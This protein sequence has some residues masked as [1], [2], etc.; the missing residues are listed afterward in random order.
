MTGT[1][2]SSRYLLGED[3][4]SFTRYRLFNQVY[5]PATLARLSELSIA[6]DGEVLEIGC[7]IG[8]TACHLAKHLVPQGHVTAF[9][10]AA[11]LV[12][13]AKRQAEDAG[14]ENVTFSCARA[15]DFDYEPARWDL[16][17]SRYVLSYLP[18]ADEVLHRV[19][20][21][22]KPSGSY[23]G[24]EIAQLYITH[25]ETAWYEELGTWFARLI[26][27]GG[28]NPNY[29]TEQLTGDLLNA[30]F[31]VLSATAVWPLE[32]QAKIIEMLRLALSREMTQVLLDQKIASAEAIA[33][34]IEAL[35]RAEPNYVISPAVAAQVIG[36][37]P[38]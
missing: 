20:T 38:Q 15:Q 3:S 18:D 7:G 23:F 6:P 2:E 19:F 8:D 27:A 36:R 13:A 29:G 33:G 1:S 26:E 10:Q 25:G 5:Q 37:K 11:D 12:E 30:G 24:E 17:H 9:D 4:D 14:I 16:A 21:A 28:G 34:A 31:N 35:S 32:D 22:L